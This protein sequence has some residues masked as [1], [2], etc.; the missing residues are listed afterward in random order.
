MIFQLNGTSPESPFPDPGLAE[1]EPDGLLAVGGDLHPR[2]L[3]QAYAQGIFPWYGEDQ[4]ILWWSPDP[5]T[6]L[7]PGRIHVSRSLRR[8]LRRGGLTLRI[9]NAFDEVV[10]GCAEPRGDRQGTW[11]LPEMRD[12]Y[13]LLHEMGMG[14]SIELWDGNELVGGLYGVAL[15]KAFFGESMFSRTPGASKI[16]MVYLCERMQA[17]EYRFLD[18]QVFNPH[19]ASM[20]AEEMPRERFLRELESAVTRTEDPAMWRVDAVGCDELEHARV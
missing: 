2:R 15:G 3:L 18:C 11:L 6:I 5:R 9:D 7:Y 19:L 14:H 13:R 17:F 20:G 4:P 12:A 16:V 8:Q 10:R 1:S